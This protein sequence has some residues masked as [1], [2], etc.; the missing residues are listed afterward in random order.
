MAGRRAGQIAATRAAMILRYAGVDDVRLL[1][2]GYDGGCRAGNP[3]ES[4][5]REPSPV[6]A[7]GVA[8]PLRPEVIVD[9]G[10]PRRSSPTRRA[11]PS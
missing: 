10:R 6:A 8:I 9:I 3:L 11:P 4:V 7:F 5:V 1:D 2:G